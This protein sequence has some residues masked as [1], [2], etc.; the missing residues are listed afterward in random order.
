MCGIVGYLGDQPFCDFILT[1]LKLLQNRGYDSAGLSYIENDEI[2]TVKYASSQTNDSIAQLEKNIQD[3]TIEKKNFLNETV[4]NSIGHT[5]WA[6]HGAKTQLNAHPHNDDKNRISLVHNGII[7]NFQELKTQL[8]KSGYPFYSQTDTEVIAALIGKY[9]DEGCMM[10]ECIQKTVA[11]LSGTW[12]LVILHK[13][14]P[15]KLWACR[16]GSPLLLGIEDQYVMIASEH[17]AFGPYIQKY[18]VL[19]NHDILEITKTNDNG[20]IYNNNV[21]KYQIQEKVIS[22]IEYEPTGFDHWMIKE[23][24]D[25]TDAIYRAINHGGRIS[26]ATNVKLGGLDSYRQQLLEIDHLILLG[27]GTSY[28][29]GLWALD[30]FKQLDIFITISVYD[31]AEFDKRD[32]PYYKNN[33]NNKNKNNKKNKRTGI[34]LLSQS[35]ETKDLHR[36]IQIANENNVVTIGL[37]N[38]PDSTIARESDCGVYLNA[39][40]E[41][42]VASTKS[43]TSQC[44]VLALVA[45]WFSQERGTCLTKRKKILQDIY[46]L[47]VQLKVIL[48]KSQ[49]DVI[50]NTAK[51]KMIK[52]KEITS[53][54]LLGKASLEAIAKEGSLKLKEVAYIHAEGF[55]ASALKHGPLALICDKTPILLIDVDDQHR[56]KIQNA[57]HEVLARGA[58]VIH[59][60][61]SNACKIDDEHYTKYINFMIQKNNTFSGILANV[62]VQLLSYYLAL[63]QGINPDFPRNLAKVVTVE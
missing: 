10:E 31:G 34:I 20:I 21:S 16:N 6:T 9:L 63:E 17:I 42:A 47:P 46:K 32:I 50:K 15:N 59:I 4:Y 35:G 52:L 30:I 51:D 41:V 61:D 60:S 26:S 28:H 44:V 49:L 56:S 8:M 3:I 57:M 43:F 2:K 39:G 55:S 12:A 22:S 48:D 1:G 36:C 37:V 53:F 62:Y 7:E 13:D 5:R 29:A 27:C 58:S 18:I 25:Q 23:I 24:F 45:V 11:M 54:F 14:F 19:D 38:V 33:N 40:R